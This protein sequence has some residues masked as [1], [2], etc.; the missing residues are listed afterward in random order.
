M[1][2]SFFGFSVSKQ[3]HK[4]TNQKTRGF[5][6]FDFQKLNVKR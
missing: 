4:E 1:C 5:L 2:D 3:N 6:F